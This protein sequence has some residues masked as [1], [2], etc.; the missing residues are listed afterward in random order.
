[1]VIC[2]VNRV[3]IGISG[4]NGYRGKHSSRCERALR[5]DFEMVSWSGLYRNSLCFRYAALGT[6]NTNFDLE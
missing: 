5:L 3:F 1:L 4:G 2:S 6:R